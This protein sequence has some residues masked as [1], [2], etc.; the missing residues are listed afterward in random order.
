MIAEERYCLD[1]LTQL[2]AARTAIRAVEAE[3]YKR[4]LES[5]VAN[6]LM[7]PKESAEKITEIKKFM[8]FMG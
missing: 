3:I 1:I 7:N 5:C 2:R 4:H 6:S 8:D